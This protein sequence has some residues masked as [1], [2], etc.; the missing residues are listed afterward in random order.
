MF[1][2]LWRGNSLLDCLISEDASLS[3]KLN[4][5]DHGVVIAMGGLM[6]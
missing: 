5:G 1:D 3:S 2:N 6:R 4:F